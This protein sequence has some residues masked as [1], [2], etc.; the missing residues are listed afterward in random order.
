MTIAEIASIAGVC[1]IGIGLIATWIH[2]GRNQAEQFGSLKTDVVN[3]Q[4]CLEDPD[5]GLSTLKDEIAEF[6]THCAK[7]STT[8]CIQVKSHEKA[9]DELKKD[10]S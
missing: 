3:I 9:I 2:N 4:K 8:L 5:H 10:S 7:V 1:F 6:K